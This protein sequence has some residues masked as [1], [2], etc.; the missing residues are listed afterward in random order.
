[1]FEPFKHT[2]NIQHTSTFE[3]FFGDHYI[4]LSLWVRLG[5][6]NIHSHLRF[7]WSSLQSCEFVCVWVVETYV[8]HSIR[9]YIDVH[10]YIHVSFAHV[11]GL[12]TYTSNIQYLYIYIYI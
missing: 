10:I 3:F 1:M 6:P 4:A 9:I 8:Q 12:A 7:I 5:S 11:F 2:F